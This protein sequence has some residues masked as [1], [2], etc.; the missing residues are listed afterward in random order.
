MVR[1]YMR[2]VLHILTA[3]MLPPKLGIGSGKLTICYGKQ[4]PME[5]DDLYYHCIIPGC[6]FHR[7]FYVYQKKTVEVSNNG[8]S[9]YQKQLDS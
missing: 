3:Q 9:P 5:I 7:F 1:S 2:H 8:I 6:F 4:Q